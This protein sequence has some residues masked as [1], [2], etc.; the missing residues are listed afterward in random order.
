MSFSSSNILLSIWTMWAANPL[1]LHELFFLFLYSFCVLWPRIKVWE[2]ARRKQLA[3]S[4]SRLPAAVLT[5]DQC[6]QCM[7]SLYS[8]AQG[9]MCWALYSRTVWREKDGSVS[10]SGPQE[11]WKDNSPPLL[12]LDLMQR[13]TICEQWH[14]QIGPKGYEWE[15]SK[16][17]HV[18]VTVKG[19]V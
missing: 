1:K 8:W 7:K 16:P 10:R 12:S 19:F 11:W 17:A 2:S 3:A 4:L 6:T 9:P 18:S 14:S 5:E 15:T 13:Q